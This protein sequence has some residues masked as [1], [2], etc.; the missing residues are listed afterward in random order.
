MNQRSPSEAA[1]KEN[2]ARTDS[3]GKGVPTGTP[4]RVLFGQFH[5]P[6]FIQTPPNKPELAGAGRRDHICSSNMRGVSLQ[7]LHITKASHLALE[8][9]SE[10]LSLAMTRML[11]CCFVFFQKPTRLPNP[12]QFLLSSKSTT[13][14]SLA[15]KEQEKV[16]Y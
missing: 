9:S 15:S 10:L 8:T 13:G 7:K 14:G 11:M 2:F 5:V 4:Q 6:K 3:Q 12:K 1:A 16:T